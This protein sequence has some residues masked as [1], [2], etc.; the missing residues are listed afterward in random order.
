MNHL[1]EIVSDKKKLLKVLGGVLVLKIS[2]EVINFIKTK[3]K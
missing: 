3:N 1:K 2:F